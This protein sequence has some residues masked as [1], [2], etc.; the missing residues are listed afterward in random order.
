M[1]QSSLFSSV[2]D[3]CKVFQAKTEMDLYPAMEL[4]KRDLILLEVKLIRYFVKDDNGH[5]SHHQAQFELQSVSLLHS[6]D[7]YESNNSS[8]YDIRDLHI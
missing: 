8:N 2:Y 5:Y 1:R 6:S 3:A 7:G 4:K